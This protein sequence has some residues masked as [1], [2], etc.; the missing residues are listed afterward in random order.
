MNPERKLVGRWTAAFSLAYVAGMLFTSAPDVLQFPG[1]EVVWTGARGAFAFGLMGLIQGFA[2]KEAGRDVSVSLFTAWTSA[3][4]LVSYMAIRWT[5]ESIGYS[6]D[7]SG[8][9]HLSVTLLSALMI[10]LGLAAAQMIPLR[11]ALPRT[12]AWPAAVSGVWAL[13]LTLESGI[14]A[15]A[16]RWSGTDAQFIGGVLQG[17]LVCMTIGGLSG[18]AASV[19]TKPGDTNEQSRRTDETGEGHRC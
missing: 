12:W 17:A 7:A 6:T 3:A 10:G 9:A 11:K 8:R 4:G 5:L 14:G 2:L 16:S 15:A 1:V 13:G 18:A 19:L